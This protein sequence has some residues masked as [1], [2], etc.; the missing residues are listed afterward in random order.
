MGGASGAK[1]YSGAED[2]HGSGM[3]SMTGSTDSSETASM[4]MKGVKT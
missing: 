1:S 2:H 4:A 3:A